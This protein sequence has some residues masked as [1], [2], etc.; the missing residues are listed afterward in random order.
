MHMTQRAVSKRPYSS[1][2][3][4]LL[5]GAIGAWLRIISTVI[6]TLAVAM[7]CGSALAEENSILEGAYVSM[8]E[9]DVF[10]LPP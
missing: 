10:S 1:K 8:S 7:L 4:S 6:V 5:V 3:L 2:V 9:T